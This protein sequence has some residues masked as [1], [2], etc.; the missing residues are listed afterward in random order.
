M[1]PCTDEGSIHMSGGQSLP[2]AI[3]LRARRVVGV[4]ETVKK[5]ENVDL[6]SPDKASISLRSPGPGRA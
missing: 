4:W 1:V 3:W 2:L 6:E 5:V